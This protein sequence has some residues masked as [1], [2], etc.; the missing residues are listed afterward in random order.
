MTLLLPF[1]LVAASLLT[2][3]VVL[4]A[5]AKI[6]AVPQAAVVPSAPAGNLLDNGSFEAP[7]IADNTF[8]EFASGLTNWSIDSGSID[9]VNAPYWA[10]PEG[11]QVLDI[12]GTTGPNPVGAISQQL[13][14][15][16]GTTYEIG[17]VYSGNPD[18]GN[19][20]NVTLDVV[21]NGA[22]VGTV[23]H[24]TVL[25]APP[26]Y[27]VA[28]FDYQ[29]FA[30]DVTG[31]VDA[32]STLSLE[33]NSA[34]GNTCGIVLDD[35]YIVFAA[36][37]VWQAVGPGLVSVLNDG[38]TGAPKFSYD[39]D[40]LHAGSI[41]GEWSFF[42]QAT[43][44][45]VVNVPY[46]YT[47]LH[48]WFNVTVTLDAFVIGANSGDVTVSIVDDGPAIC[49]TPPSNG[50]SYAGTVPLTLEAGDIYGFTMSGSNGD[51]NTFLRGEFTVGGE[52]PAP[53]LLR[54]VS[55]GG[56]NVTV[57]G[58]VDG[59]PLTAITL[60]GSTADT[61]TD[62]VLNG[63]AAATGTPTVTTDDEGYFAASFSGVQPGDYVT[64]RLTSPAATAEF[65]MHG[66]LGRQ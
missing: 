48:A 34:P 65:G 30:V 63:G 39:Y 58:R 19:I 56:T 47:G 27:S 43:A 61:C 8:A 25:N 64:A 37:P 62:G 50:F 57:L 40:L 3:P 31:G 10:A 20:G 16:P 24:D 6:G 60:A 14:T 1:L 46:T 9:L 32:E 33:L 54:A 5:P 23:S 17:F 28:S 52:A 7:A 2:T 44:D 22:V 15:T 45:G 35:V 21:W 38:S 59:L 13:L 4:A 41:N 26:D 18:C 66:Q 12:D 51:F 55:T 36:P 42:T 11:D 29:T 49:C 53:E